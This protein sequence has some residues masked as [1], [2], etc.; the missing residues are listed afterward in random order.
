MSASLTIRP[1]RESDLAAADQLFRLA[2][3]TWF[4]LP[5]PMQFRGDALLFAP[6]WKTYRDGGLVAE[7]DGEIVGLTF[8]SRWGGLGVLGPAAIHPKLWRQGIARAMLP[9]TLAIFERWQTK[10]VGLFTFP[11]SATHLRLYQAFGFWPRHFTPIL[12]KAVAAPATNAGA[13]LLSAARERPAVVAACRALTDAIFPGLDL[14]AEIDVV[15]DQKFG[16]VVALEAGS[17]IDGFAI[18]HTGAGSEG[19]SKSCYVKFGAVRP[20]DGAADRL[21]RLVAAC[22]HFAQTRGVPQISLG[23][24]TGRHHAYRLLVELGFR[25]QPPLGVRMHRPWQDGYDRADDF[26]IDDWR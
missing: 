7:L 20:G 21:T 23:V 10:L 26:V 18:C 17:R 8:A 25:Q 4:Q 1:L 19:G 24:S 2:F 5:D 6:R 9:E 11:Q 3:G 13:L 22:E 12:A 15:L 16:D 14:T